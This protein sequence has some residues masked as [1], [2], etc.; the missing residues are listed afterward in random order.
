MKLSSEGGPE[1]RS[2]MSSGKVLRVCVTGAAG[3]IAYSLLPH[4]CLGRTFGPDTGI[5]LHLL[6]IERAQT[7]IPL[8]PLSCPC[9]AHA[10]LLC[11]GPGLFAP[12][13][14]RTPSYA[15]I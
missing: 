4:I 2:A 14:T 15:R 10:H 11:E 9:R 3:Q 5:I 1:L 8:N 13:H 12:D 6:D 7:V